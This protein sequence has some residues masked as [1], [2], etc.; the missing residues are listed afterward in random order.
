MGGMD[1]IEDQIAWRQEAFSLFDVD[2][3]GHIAPPELGFLM[4]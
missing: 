2:W 1:L 4:R 3:D